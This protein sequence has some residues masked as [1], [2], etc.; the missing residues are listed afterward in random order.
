MDRFERAGESFARLCQLMAK[1]RAPGGCPW[2][3]EQ[4]LD[5]LK[6]YLIEEAYEVL[7]ALELG[8]ADKHREELGDLLL[9]VVFQAEVVQETGGFDIDSVAQTL[10]DKLV[11]RHPHV[12][13]DTNTAADDAAGALRNWE[14]IKAQE[15]SAK[16]VPGSVLDGIPANLP[17]LLR[18]T[19]TGE[20]AA[21]IGFDWP[22]VDGV[23]AKVKEEWREVHDAVI[24]DPGRVHEEMGDLLL[25]LVS[26]SRHLGID[27][28]AA[29]RDAT[30]KFQRRFRHV[31]RRV[32]EGRLRGKTPA[33]ETLDALERFWEEAK[34]THE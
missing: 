4:T 27:P 33:D 1:L 28:E 22:N 21:A 32:L 2:D 29:L 20:K 7:E 23:E 31:E 5:S 24:N 19:R 25:A 8:D 13:G 6:P 18:A 14:S 34:S 10:I 3:A 12:F 17:A 26:W 16:K 15:R 11:R 30:N 9:Q